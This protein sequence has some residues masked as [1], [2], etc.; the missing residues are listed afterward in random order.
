[1]NIDGFILP[2]HVSVIIGTQAYRPFFEETGLPCVVAGFEPADILQAI[3]MLAGQISSGTPKL[4]NAYRRAVTPE[5]N[6]KAQQILDIVFEPGDAEWRGIGTIPGSGLK[7][8]EAFTAF[9]AVKRFNIETPKAEDPKG[10]GCGEILL[11]VK[12]PPECPLYKRSCTPMDP[13]GPCMVSTEGTCAAYYRYH[14][15]N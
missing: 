10:C 12:T 3:A 9:D 5:G 15:E 4:E 8:K 11:G 7:L 13:I 2:G 6:P 14:T 1:M